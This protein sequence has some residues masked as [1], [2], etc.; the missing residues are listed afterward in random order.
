MMQS[1]ESLEVRL[2]QETL[3]QSQSVQSDKERLE[4][5]ERKRAEREERRAEKIK[6]RSSMVFAF[7]WCNSFHT[8]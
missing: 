4:Q 2:A 1:S 8:V 3:A 6:R 5:I 7:L